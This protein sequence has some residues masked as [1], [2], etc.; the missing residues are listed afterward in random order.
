MKHCKVTDNDN[1]FIGY[2]NIAICQRILGD[3]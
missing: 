1:A 3:Y 2:Y